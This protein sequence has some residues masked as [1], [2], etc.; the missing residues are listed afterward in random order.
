MAGDILLSMAIFIVFIIA[1]LVLIA[2]ICVAIA[3]IYFAL[4]GAPYANTLPSRI[5]EMM[6][7]AEVKKGERAV[8]IGSGDGRIVI[9]LAKRGVEAHGYEI[10]PLLVLWS[11][12]KLKRAG[13]SDRAFIH[14]KDMWRHDYSDFDL[15]ISCQISYMMG[16]LEKKLRREIKPGARVVSNYFTFPTWKPKKKKGYVYLYQVK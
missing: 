6:K 1:L 15:I 5:E 3:T 8:D 12:Y 4:R 11:R 7:L 10:N 13:V 16:R 2:L 9:A 14:F